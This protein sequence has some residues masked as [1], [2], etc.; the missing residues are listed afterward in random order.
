MI[1][2]GIDPNIIDS[3]NFT[4]SW[5]GFF[6]FIAVATAV[7]LSARWAR[8]SGIVSDVVYSTAIWAI[9]GGILGA[10]IVHVVDNWNSFYS[11]NPGQ[12]LAI[13]SGG[14]GL[15]GAIL[16]G[17]LGGAAYAWLSKYPIGKLADATAPA[18][19]I[20]QSIGRIGDV[21]NGEHLTKTTNLPWGLNYQHV[22]SPA[23][24]QGS[25]HP[26]VGYEIIW[27]MIALAIV[28]QFRD[29]LRP[30]GM[31][32]VLYLALYATGR[33][34]IQ[35]A[36]VDKVW[37]AGLHEAHFIALIVL[38][39]TVP[40]LIFKAKLTPGDEAT[41]KSETPNGPESTRRPRR[42]RYGL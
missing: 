28:W 18:M 33:F 21:I 12:I 7:F 39:I 5:H 27:N 25:Q 4:L 8:R 19:L 24:G 10:R 37:I 22:G 17:F 9:I 2:I 31:L 23:F 15:W 16:G 36:R 3:G 30:D 20:V 1:D 40:L 32:F 14:I 35:F 26:A 29:K 41:A 34:A 11:D 6:S 38:A 13:W 42:R